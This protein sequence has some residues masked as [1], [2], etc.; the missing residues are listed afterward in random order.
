VSKSGANLLTVTAAGGREGMWGVRINIFILHI[1]YITYLLNFRQPGRQIEDQSFKHPDNF[2]LQ[3]LNDGILPRNPFLIL[4]FL[5]R[6]SQSK[7][8]VRVV[9]G[10]EVLNDMGC[11]TV[12]WLKQ[13]SLTKPV[14]KLSTMYRYDGLYQVDRVSTSRGFSVGGKILTMTLFVG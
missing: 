1:L 6:S 10:Y 14:R 11:V 13:T 9:R 7:W 2:A 4:I 12:L 3:V 5:Q 8:P